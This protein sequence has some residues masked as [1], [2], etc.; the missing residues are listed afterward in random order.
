VKIVVL[1]GRPLATERSAF[2]GLDE[3]GETEV[4]DQSSPEEIRRR[5][6]GA[7]VLITNKAA[8]RADL[9]AELPELRYITLMATGYDCVDAAAA[10]ARGIP[11]SNVPIYGTDSV[12][13]HVFALLLELC[14]HVGAHAEAVRQGEWTRWPDFSMRKT[15]LYEMAGKTFGIVG[16]GRIGQRVAELA[17]AFGMKIIASSNSGRLPDGF[18]PVEWC[19]IDD[20]FARSDVISLHCPSNP[21]TVG[22]VN[23]SR[24]AL[25]KPSAYLINTA[26]GALIVEQDLADAL[27]AGRIAGAGLDVVSREPPVAGNPLFSARNCLVTPHNAWATDEAR[28][29]LMA[30]TVANVAAFLSGSPI[31]VV[32]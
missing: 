25:M 6:V 1:D 30:A 7:G 15:P 10:R 2:A 5:A 4:Y 11:V 12:A 24:L 17:R 29:R 32:N 20:L 3:L 16:L 8:I 19:A 22:L 13:Q 28:A 9:M 18:G 14:N 26:R 31:N 27:N 21:R 23:Q